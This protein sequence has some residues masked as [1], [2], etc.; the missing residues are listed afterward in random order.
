[1][2]LYALLWLLF[3]MLFL[4][5]SSVISAVLLFS[6]PIATA[7][8]CSCGVVVAA[9]SIMITIIIII[10]I[11]IVI[12]MFT[13]FVKKERERET[14]DLQWDF[15][16]ESERVLEWWRQWCHWVS[17]LS[18]LVC[19]ALLFCSGGTVISRMSFLESMLWFCEVIVTVIYK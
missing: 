13:R 5:C 14:L 3:V 6:V 11:I 12:I 2:M 16:N 9:R 7:S 17:T 18:T 4:L 15:W 1:M 10:I 8:A 19:F